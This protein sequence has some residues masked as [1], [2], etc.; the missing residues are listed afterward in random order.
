MKTNTRKINEVCQIDSESG[1]SWD[2]NEAPVWQPSQFKASSLKKSTLFNSHCLNSSYS[3]SV[4]KESILGLKERIAQY[5]AIIRGK[6]AQI[7]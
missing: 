6:D 7:S 4:P 1:S 3:T 5:L 2:E